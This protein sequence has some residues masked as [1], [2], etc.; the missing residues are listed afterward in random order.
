MDP[1]SVSPFTWVCKRDGRL[2]PFDADRIS[3]SLFA[4]SERLGQ[5]DAFLARELTDGILHFLAADAEGATPSTAQIAEMVIKVVRELGQ[6]ALSRA[7]SEL[8][9]KHRHDKPHAFTPGRPGDREV[10]DPHWQALKSMIDAAPP[11][12]HLA[13]QLSGTILRDYSLREVFARD[14]AAAHA[15]GLLVLGNLETPLELAGCVLGPE[16]AP[17]ADEGLMRRLVEARS[18]AGEFLAIDSPEFSLAAKS[19]PV[20]AAT[21]F[22]RELRIGLS[23]TGLRAIVNL[24]CAQA[25]AW[26]GDLADGPLF[27]GQAPSVEPTEPLSDALLD[28]LTEAHSAS[29]S[30]TVRVDWHLGQRDFEPAGLNRLLRTARR[31]VEGA[32]LTFVFDRLRRPPALAEGIDR[33]HPATLLAVGL[34]LGQLAEQPEVKR[35]SE[36]FLR[37]LGSLVRLAL[38]AATQKRDFLRRHRQAR[39]AITRGFLLNRARLV[40]VPIGLEKAA[41]L[42]AGE[43]TCSGASGLA[44]G[45]QVVGRLRD[46]LRQD[47]ASYH[48]ETCLDGVGNFTLK[49]AEVNASGLGNV[50][51]ENVA[52]LTSW[53]CHAPM[54]SQLQAIGALHAN[55]AGTGALLL[56]EIGSVTGELVADWLRLA[57]EKTDIVRLRF[58]QVAE[59]PKQLTA[60]WEGVVEVSKPGLH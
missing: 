42:L 44:F 17:R 39:P 16:T 57:W 19:A 2:V 36:V 7:Y 20:S 10:A 4:A 32:N 29:E 59:Q 8:I 18:I 33:Q 54:K 35:D 43:Y 40:L 22:A 30:A 31:A 56:P 6:P 50:L 27:A 21:D 53:N 13:W 23:A 25:P 47:G 52:G 41:H 12:P 26:A 49:P 9:E 37:K 5:A 3:R 55:E 24:N 60:P 28:F 15:Q 38:S 14:L 11:T 45:R 46:Y 48:L 34:D 58:V 1:A 51:A